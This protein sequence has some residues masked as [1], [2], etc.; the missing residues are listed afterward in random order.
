MKYLLDLQNNEL[1]NL[2]VDKNQIDTPN[3]I[4]N[5]DESLEFTDNDTVIIAY[6]FTWRADYMK[7]DEGTSRTWKFGLFDDPDDGK[8]KYVLCD[9]ISKRLVLLANGESYTKLIKINKNDLGQSYSVFNTSLHSALSNGPSFYNPKYVDYYIPGIKHGCYTWDSNVQYM[10]D[11]PYETY[12]LS[13]PPY[14]VEEG[15]TDEEARERV[16]QAQLDAFNASSDEIKYNTAS[17]KL[18]SSYSFYQACQ[19]YPNE[20]DQRKY[21]LI[22]LQG[23]W[24]DPENSSV[25]NQSYR[26][27]ELVS[28]IN[29]LSSNISE[30]QL[31]NCSSYYN[32]KKLIFNDNIETLKNVS[33]SSATFNE[34]YFPKK[35]KNLVNG[36]FS[37][38]KGKGYYETNKKYGEV[39]IELGDD[40]ENIPGSFFN[41]GEGTKITINLPKKLKTIGPNAFMWFDT[42]SQLVIPA[43]VESIGVHESNSQYNNIAFSPYHFFKYIDNDTNNVDESSFKVTHIPSVKFEGSIPPTMVIK[44]GSNTPSGYWQDFAYEYDETTKRIVENAYGQKQMQADLIEATYPIYVP[45]GSKAAYIAALPYCREERFIEY[46]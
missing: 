22:C 29:F 27:S 31:S 37:Y 9:V 21:C 11:H 38:L 39:Y 10:I 7:R 6:T 1:A 34:I 8:T 46:D 13:I 25:I 44:A 32:A 26:N 36:S 2:T 4:L 28:A 23:V 41:N 18:K 14:T 30:I 19:C 5:H 16:K 42:D 20:E 24:H 45:R 17:N 40:L 15:E 33:F 35:L 12:L 43:S 3:I